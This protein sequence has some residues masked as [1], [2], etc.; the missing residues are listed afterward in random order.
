MFKDLAAAIREGK[1]PAVKWSESAEVI[2]II[3]LAKQ[4]AKEERTIVVPPRA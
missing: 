4:S 1:T 3:E 2:E